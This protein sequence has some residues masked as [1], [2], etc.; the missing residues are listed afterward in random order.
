MRYIVYP[1]QERS[2]GISLVIP[3][4]EVDIE[5][6]ALKDVP[7]GLPFLYVNAD[8]LPD[9]AFF[10]AWEANFS[11]PDGYGIGHEAWALQQEQA[12]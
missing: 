12:Q 10:E 9:D 4:G 1:N 5:Q 6:V 2:G 7:A 11:S 3:T 8:Q